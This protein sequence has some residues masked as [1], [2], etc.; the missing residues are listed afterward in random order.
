MRP[1]FYDF[2]NTDGME[3]D[4]VDDQFLIGPAIMQAPVVHQGQQRAWSHCRARG[5]GWMSTRAHF[6]TAGAPSM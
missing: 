6:L 3:L 2:A 1:L 4:R 5:A